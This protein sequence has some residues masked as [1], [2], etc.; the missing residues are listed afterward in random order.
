MKVKKI[1]FKI[2]I[3]SLLFVI[4]SM[5]VNFGLIQV[6]IDKSIASTANIHYGQI[7]GNL[8]EYVRMLKKSVEKISSNEQIIKIL[9]ENKDVNDLSSE[10]IETVTGQID[11]LEGIISNMT[12]VNTINIVS[13][14]GK[15]LFSKGNLYEDFELTERAW[16]KNEYLENKVETII[17]TIHTDY[18][19]KE[20]TIAMVSFIYSKDGSEVLGAAV[21]DIFV[22]DMLKFINE[23]FV[24]GNLESYIKSSNGYTYSENGVISDEY[25]NKIYYNN[26]YLGVS[27]GDTVGKEG[28]LQFFFEKESIKNNE[29]NSH[30]QNNINFMVI[31]FGLIIGILLMISIKLIYKPVLKVMDKLKALL[32][33]VSDNTL[34]KDISNKNNIKQLEIISDSLE[35]SFDR[36]IKE[37]I[38]YDELTKLPNRKKIKL[39][40]E[41]MLRNEEPFALIFLDLNKFKYV[42]DIYGHSVGDELLVQ[43]SYIIKSLVGDKGIV[44]R[45]SGDEF[46]IVYKDYIGESELIRFYNDNIKSKFENP[47]SINDK[48]K[49]HIEF[50]A[51]VAVYPYHGTTYNELIKKSDFM[52]YKNKQSNTND[53]LMFNDE[54]YKESLY[55]DT[56][57][58]ELKNAVKNDEFTLYYQPIINSE[59]E[60]KKA[61]ALI[62]WNNSKLGFVPP[63]KFINY[64]EETRDIIEIGY[65]IIDTVCKHLKYLQENG[66]FTQININVSPVQLLEENFVRNSIKIIEK[67]GID[68]KDLCFE[69]TESV[70]LDNN[71]VVSSNLLKLR[72]LG[73]KI[74]LDDFG[75]G[76]SSFSYLKKYKL[77]ILKLDK[78]FIQDSYDNDFKIVSNIKDIAKTLGMDIVIEGVETKEQFKDILKLDKIFIQ[79]SYDNDFKIVSNIKDIAKT[80]GMDIVIEGVET[81]EQFN[82]LSDIGC[83]LF[84]GY[85]FSRPILLDDF[86]ELIEKNSIKF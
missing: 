40:C 17:T 52:M 13:L 81:K 83:D 12:F 24:Y 31:M 50:S 41:E 33:E 44:F 9:E 75:T 51:G 59:K 66:I 80:L 1:D 21:L 84:Q 49:M 60:I 72:E 39:I 70:V 58:S 2:I 74:A 82:I 85:Y 68:Y 38:Y 42:N 36:K 56:L 57:K 67:H 30:L 48:L 16:F 15:Y 77:D 63:D 8:K 37:L 78:I 11:T 26:S 45:Y 55:I 46:I 79:D 65:W 61:E 14:D 5:C 34:V 28:S 73:I 47:V 86:K 53:L 19:T 18:T 27:S 4:I 71:K 64:S 25:M 62:R 7:V 22:T 35:K 69:I 32:D 10:D 43:F 76:Y 6:M 23:S 54:L 3:I 20:S 29:L